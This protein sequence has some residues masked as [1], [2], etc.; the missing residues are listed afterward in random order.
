MAGAGPVGDRG[1]AAGGE[2]ILGEPDP[3]EVPVARAGF[4]RADMQFVLDAL[5]LL[6]D[7]DEPGVEVDVP[8]AEAED[9]GTAHA[10]EDSRGPVPSASTG[11]SQ[12]CDAS[13]VLLA[14]WVA[15]PI[16]RGVFG[17]QSVPTPIA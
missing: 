9:R 12:V 2:C 1:F 6:T 17:W 11:D 10:V 5:D 7:P 4:D 14:I 16:A 3:W 13:Q 15:G 8:P